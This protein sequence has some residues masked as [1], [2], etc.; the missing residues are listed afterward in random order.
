MSLPKS[1]LIRHSDITVQRCGQTK[2]SSF[3]QRMP[4]ATVTHRVLKAKPP[5]NAVA[6]NST[7]PKKTNNNQGETSFAGAMRVQK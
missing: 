4:R 6:P 1:R 7:R 5:Q 3:R 2:E